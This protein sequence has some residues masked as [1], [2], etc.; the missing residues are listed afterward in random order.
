[1]DLVAHVVN[2]ALKDLDRFDHSQGVLIQSIKGP[3]N[4]ERAKSEIGR[5]K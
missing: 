1:M 5:L 2:Q 3:D 4:V